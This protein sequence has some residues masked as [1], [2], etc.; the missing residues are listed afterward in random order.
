MRSYSL[1]LFPPSIPIKSHES[2]PFL[3]HGVWIPSLLLYSIFVVV[4]VT[5]TFLRIFPRILSSRFWI[6][7]LIAHDL[8]YRTENAVLALNYRGVQAR[9]CV[10]HCTD[11]R[12][13][14]GDT[15]F[16]LCAGLHDGV[17]KNSWGIRYRE[18]PSIRCFPAADPPSS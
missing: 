17:S 1:Q 6:R 14:P 12:L 13:S 3:S 10:P 15:Y 7:N 2:G 5:I 4:A 8:M 16:L 18:L 11:S 9:I